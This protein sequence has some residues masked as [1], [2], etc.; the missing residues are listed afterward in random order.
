MTLTELKYIVAVA[1]ERHFGRAAAACFVSQP[2]LSVGVKRIEDTLGVQIF[3][4][5]SRTELRITPR[6]EAII[7][8][9]Q[10]VLQEAEQLQTLADAAKDPL[11]G[12]LRI[13]LIYT[14]G[15]YLL[16]TLIPALHQRA[17][18]MPVEIVEGFTH[19]LA[20]QLHQGA[21]DAVVLSLPF[22]APRLVITPVYREPFTVAV[23]SEHP[24]ASELGQAGAVSM[25]SLAAQDLLMLGQG[26]C[27]RD[28][29][30][31][32]CPACAQPTSSGRLQK[33][34]EGGSLETMR[35]MVAS[36]AGITVLPC[37]SNTA[38]AG[39]AGDLIRYFPFEQP[40]PYR[41]V[42]VASRER[43]ARYAAVDLL[44][45]LIRAH[46]PACCHAI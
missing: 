15:P 2:T 26:H 12:T 28:Q 44:S 16:P 42:A 10:R 45:D 1:R 21:L 31:S 43:F 20:H 19:D 4:R 41:D 14:I 36:G 35:M 25:A 18:R 13:G 9:A 39:Q 24:L 32:M 33:T 11:V 30:L 23:P 17:P 22:S 38:H 7:E 6:G 34:L 40:A 46:K 27:F 37:S 3:E 5:A 8:Q 29:V